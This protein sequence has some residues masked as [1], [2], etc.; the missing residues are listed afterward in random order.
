M[1]NSGGERNTQ[2]ARRIDWSWLAVGLIV[3]GAAWLRWHLLDVPLERDEGEYAY[4]GQLLLQGVPPYQLLYNMKLPGIYAVYAAILAIF[5]Q[6]QTGIHLGLLAV[7]AASIVLIFLLGKR[8]ASPVVGVCAGAIF[9]VLSMGQSV[10]GIFA[11]AEHFVVLP[12]LAGLF[13]LL[14]GLDS[15]RHFFIFMG[16]ILLGTGFLIKQHGALFAV[17]G[18]LYLVFDGWR[19][20][21]CRLLDIARQLLLLV[22]GAALP[23]LLTCLLL[24]KAGVFREFWFWTIDYARAYASQVSWNDAW[25]N[26]SNRVMTIVSDAPLLWLAVALGTIACLTRQRDIRRNFFI[27]GFAVFS[28]LALCP[29]LFFRPHYFILLLPGAA[30]LAGIA[31]H[32][33]VTV[34]FGGHWQ[35]KHSGLA[36]ALLGL[37]L[38][39]ALYQQ[40]QFL[41]QFS[42]AQASTDTYWPNPFNESLEI[43]R[44]IRS[45]SKP[46]DTIAIIG[47]EPQIFFYAGR[48]SA[49]GYIYMYPLMEG[50]DFALEMQQGLIAEVERA[51]PE[52][53][54]FVRVP[55]SWLQTPTSKTMIYDWFTAYKEKYQRV[56]MVEIFEKFSTISWR[57]DVH[58]PPTTPYWIE[59]LRKN[60]T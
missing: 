60:Q 22:G 30:L 52:Y 21:R 5:G 31:I 32:S 28:F 27:L 56:G 6:S 17:W 42:P 59:V 39:G 16:G 33:T 41:F 40:R 50:H 23:Y 43:A 9:A 1:A 7:N 19:N 26:L 24:W 47:S 34:I 51:E 12:A 58:W 15:K 25:L 49:T 38:G 20:N 11:N 8:C 4:G 48:R 14:L 55:T 35:S 18:G 44:Y 2:L 13:F 53:L 36:L 57:S 37:C 29:G 54:I 46:T 45:N 3:L 10:Q